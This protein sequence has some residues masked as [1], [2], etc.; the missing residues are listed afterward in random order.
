VRVAELGRADALLLFLHAP[1]RLEGETHRP[2][3]V[4]VG[5]LRLGQRVD[6]LE[7][8][9]D[10]LR[11]RREV[12]PAQGTTE[13]HARLPEVHETVAAQL[14]PALG[15]EVAHEG[16]VLGEQVG[17]HLGHVP[18]GDVGVDAVHEGGVAAHLLGQRPEE[19][20]DALLVLDVDL[21]VADE[22]EAAVAADVLLA[23]A[24]LARL[25]VALHDLDAVLL[26]ERDATDL[27]EADDVVEADE[28]ALAGGVVDEH[29]RHR[30]LAPGDKVRVG[31]D[32]LVEV[33]LAGAARAEL[34][35]VVVAHDE[36]HHAQHEHVALA[37]S[38]G[39]RLEPRTA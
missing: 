38:K 32:L 23:A 34:D 33:R 8:P 16:E 39:I 13:L 37:L 19:V 30:H 3:E 18:A 1:P 35:G 29:L 14:V 10:G 28:A 20:A 7:E 2:L 25:H 26:V 22:D 15:E 21:E 36:R 6:Q 17:V 9:V 27:V 31:R 5:N 4:D 12:A 11:D 24:E